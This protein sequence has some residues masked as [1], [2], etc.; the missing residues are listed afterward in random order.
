MELRWEND[1]I[2]K[3]KIENGCA[4]ISANRSGLL[5]LAEHL[6][7]LAKQDKGA[8]IHYDEYNSLE[9]GSDELIIER[10]DEKE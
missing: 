9:D 7:E 10:I 1:P 2:I 6:T 5:S 4:L 3:V 8:H